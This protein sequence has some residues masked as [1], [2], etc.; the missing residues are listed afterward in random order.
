MNASIR[1]VQS[2]ELEL[3]TFQNSE[4]ERTVFKNPQLINSNTPVLIKSEAT[5]SYLFDGNRIG[6]PREHRYE[7]EMGGVSTVPNQLPGYANNGSDY[8]DLVRILIIELPNSQQLENEIKFRIRKKYGK[9]SSLIRFGSRKHDH[10]KCL[11]GNLGSFCAAQFRS[12]FGKTRNSI[13]S[14]I[15]A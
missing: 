5:H 10:G 14:K 6:S 4:L 11:C 13:R 12:I 2:N 15:R 1:L 3:P 8:C 9:K 7:F